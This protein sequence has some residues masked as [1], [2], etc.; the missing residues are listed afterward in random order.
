MR[1]TSSSGVVYSILG[2]VSAASAT[3]AGTPA[4]ASRTYGTG[5]AADPCGDGEVRC[6]SPLLYS[7]DTVVPL[8]S[9]DQRS[10]W[11]P[12]PYAGY[13][14]FTE[15]M[16]NVATMLGWLLSSIFVLSFARLARGSQ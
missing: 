1:A 2:P 5:P 12:D 3:A 10:T 14:V 16:L 9:L 15:W 13:G 8:I 11:Y 7:V 6:F 4:P